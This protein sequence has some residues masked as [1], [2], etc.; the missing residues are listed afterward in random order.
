[1]TKRNF[2]NTPSLLSFIEYNSGKKNATV[3]IVQNFVKHQDNGWNYT[4]DNI[5]KYLEK[6][7]AQREEIKKISLPPKNLLKL[8]I[9]DVP[10]LLKEIMNPFF[11][12]VKILG[13]RTAELHNTLSIK[14]KK[15]KEFQPEPVSKLYL[16]ALYQSIRTLTI[17]TFNNIKKSKN[18]P[19]EIKEDLDEIL[20]S[21]N[22]ILNYSKK[23][24]SSTLNGKRIRCHNDYHLGQ[25]LFTGNDF[26]IIDFEGEPARPIGERI[27]KR[28]PH[29]YIAGMIR[30]LHYSAYSI[31]FSK[32]QSFYTVER[33]N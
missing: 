25:V 29:T 3:A 24:L 15:Q 19:E 23:I 6:A 31:L 11:E 28:I 7:Y 9:S 21:Q 1:M 14:I 2:K 5:L 22:S 27:I 13:K 20:E 26:I 17:T 30:S 32:N 16:R 8:E 10:P 12:E 33:R 18:I 4:K